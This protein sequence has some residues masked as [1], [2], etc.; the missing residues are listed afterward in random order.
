[1][2]YVTR[3]LREIYTSLSAAGWIWVGL[4]TMGPQVPAVV[5]RLMDPPAAHPEQLCPHIPLTRTER[6]LQRQLMA[7]IGDKD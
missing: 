2:R 7:P 6:A 5:R 4:H 1:M 3:A